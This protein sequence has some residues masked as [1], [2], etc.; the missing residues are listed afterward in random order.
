MDASASHH[1]TVP[2]T[3]RYHTV[4]AA[5]ARNVWFVLHGYGQL[6]RYFMRPF[7]TLADGTRR[8]IA[9][10]ALS[11]FYLDGFDGRIGATWMTSADREHEIDD[12][13]RY[14]DALADEVLPET[15]DAPHITALGFSQGTATA[16]R[17]AALGRHTIDRLVL[18]AGGVPPDL[19]LAAHRAF[20]E[21]VDL[22]LIIG[23]ED[24]FIPEQ[25]VEEEIARLDEHG[26]PHR[27]IRF[28]GGHRIDP[29]VLKRVAEQAA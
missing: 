5:E 21:R 26:I 1:I 15:S 27:T 13:V 6:A 14:L 24:E 23:A 12:Y 25:R 17:W 18:W 7:A 10:E 9:P 3:A 29:A 28:D 8:I 2:R 16:C 4:G 19:D 20:F 22:T 11:R